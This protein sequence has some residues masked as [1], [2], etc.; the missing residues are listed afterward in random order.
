MIITNISLNASMIVIVYNVKY[1]FKI[2]ALIKD[3]TGT[4]KG[5]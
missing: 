2:L 5:V 3:H 1:V 4:K